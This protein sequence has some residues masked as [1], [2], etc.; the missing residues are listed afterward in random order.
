MFMDLRNYGNET[1]FSIASKYDNSAKYMDAS[2]IDADLS[3]SSGDDKRE[4]A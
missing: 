1:N 3:L 2:K 4:N